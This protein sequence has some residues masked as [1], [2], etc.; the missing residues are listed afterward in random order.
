MSGNYFTNCQAITRKRG[1]SRHHVLFLSG[2]YGVVRPFE[3]IQLYSCPLSAAIAD[4]WRKSD[5]LTSVLISYARLH[6]ITRVLDLTAVNAYRDL[7]DWQALTQFMGV[8]VL[9][10]FDAMGMGDNAL[11]PFARLMKDQLLDTSEQ[12]L[13]AITSDERRGT[14]TFRSLANAPPGLPAEKSLDLA[15]RELPLLE[16]YPIGALHEVIQGGN[17]PP[18]EQDTQGETWKG[19]WPFI[20]A[21]VFRKQVAGHAMRGRIMNA[22]LEISRD[23]IREIGDTQKPL[24]GK[25]MGKWRRRIGDYRLIYEPIPDKGVVH[26]LDFGARGNIYD[27]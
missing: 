27:D 26:L 5:V 1:G 25:L 14:V 7:V 4:E 2:L 24:L 3:S 20:I 9:H 13:M 8:Q 17:P 12:E 22:I 6:H 10:A 19:C 11:V 23:P 16:T 21:S 18:A 15:E